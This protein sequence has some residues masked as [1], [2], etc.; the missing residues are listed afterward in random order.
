M[1]IRKKRKDGVI[2]TYHVAS[3]HKTKRKPIRE[4]RMWR[5]PTTNAEREL[6][7]KAY[8]IGMRNPWASGNAAI[9]E[10]NF[11]TENDRLNK[12]SIAVVDNLENLRQIFLTGNWQLGSS[13]MYKNLVFINQIDGGDE[14]LTIKRW[15]NGEVTAFESIT[16]NGFAKNSTRFKKLIETLLKA[17]SK[18]EYYGA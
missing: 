5:K 15:P 16:M 17:K 11:I 3:P 2:Q 9:S 7:N 13:W 4:L 1:K 12:D 6:W 8:Q 18:K 10:G 14:W